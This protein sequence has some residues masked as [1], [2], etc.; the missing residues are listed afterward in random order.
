MDQVYGWRGSCEMCGGR[1]PDVAERYLRSPQEMEAL[2]A[3][4]SGSG[5]QLSG[6]LAA[7]P[8]PTQRPGLRVPANPLGEGETTISFLRERTREGFD[9]RYGAQALTST[10]VFMA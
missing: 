10:P 3:R 8:V 5:L 9:R 7:A 6:T 2:F 4:S 1:R